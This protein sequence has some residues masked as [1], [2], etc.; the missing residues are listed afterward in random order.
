MAEQR[1]R[2]VFAGEVAPGQDVE[3]VKDNLAA[4]LKLDSRQVARLF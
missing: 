4:R 1:Y 2:L 3:A